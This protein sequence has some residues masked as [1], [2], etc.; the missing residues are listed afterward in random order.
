MTLYEA[1]LTSRCQILGPPPTLRQEFYVPRVPNL[2]PAELRGSAVATPPPH[3]LCTRPR[4]RQA[5]ASHNAR[6]L[7]SNAPC[8]PPRLS[9][10]P[11]P[12]FTAR[13]LYLGAVTAAPARGTLKATPVEQ[14]SD[15]CH[16]FTIPL[17]RR[18]CKSR[19]RHDDTAA[20]TPTAPRTL[21]PP[22]PTESRPA[23][24]STPC[25]RL[26]LPLRHSLTPTAYLDASPGA[27]WG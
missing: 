17:D 2:C 24:A 25:S 10:R 19:E 9:V 7:P 27:L 6:P 1:R 4:R 3:V 13:T 15:N 21:V 20:I 18:R 16:S 23:S 5:G 22:S 14:L 26:P 12:A 8:F 11:T